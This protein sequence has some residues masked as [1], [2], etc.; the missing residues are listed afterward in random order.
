MGPIPL[1][2][3][4]ANEG[5]RPG[6]LSGGSLAKPEAGVTRTAMCSVLGDAG[7]LW[8]KAS[9]L[10]HP[11]GLLCGMDSCPALLFHLL[12]G[13]Y[14]FLREAFQIPVQ[15]RYLCGTLSQLSVHFFRAL[16][17][18]GSSGLSI[19][20]HS[21][22]EQASKSSIPSS[23]ARHCSLWTQVSQTD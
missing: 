20:K 19:A 22:W 9:G 1:S 15:I 12:P 11:R 8:A 7:S 16:T 21:A 2:V 14:P 23:H 17:I 6:P 3:L 10:S 5:R 4:T 13:Q 18:V